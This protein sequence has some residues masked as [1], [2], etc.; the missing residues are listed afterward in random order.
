GALSAEEAQQL[1]GDAVDRADAGVLYAESGGNP[2][3]LEQLAR[4]LDRAGGTAAVHDETPLAAIG[5]PSTVAA[6]LTEELA[7][8]SRSARLVLEGAAGA[9]D[10]V[11]LLLARAGAL[12]AAGRFADSHRALLDAIAIVPAESYAMRARLARACAG[13]ES[14]LGQQEQAGDRLSRALASL[15]DQG[16]R[17]AVALTLELTVNTLWRARYEAMHE[18]AERATNA[19]KQLGDKPLTAAAL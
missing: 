17:E 2:F 15:P 9:G 14:L 5:V 1:L 7:L 18:L 16:S 4:S 6:A 19:A 12:T 3:Y 11:E 13:V 10:P 8:L